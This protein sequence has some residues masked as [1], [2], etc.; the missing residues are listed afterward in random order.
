MT[1]ARPPIDAIVEDFRTM[2]RDARGRGVRVFLGTILPE[3]PDACRAGDFCDGVYDTVA[4]NAKLRA[5]ASA[6]GATLVDLYAA[7]DGQTS[8]L[9]SL[10]GLHPNEAGYSKMAETFFN[11]IRQQLEVP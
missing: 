2:I 11:A 5:L 3:R 10:D 8:A 6:E 7:F 9:L 4:T 1:G